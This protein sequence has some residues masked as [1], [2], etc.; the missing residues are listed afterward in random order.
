M[1][2]IRRLNQIAKLEVEL[3]AKRGNPLYGHID[4]MRTAARID[5]LQSR[6]PGAFNP[7]TST[8]GTI[9]T[10]HYGAHLV[11]QKQKPGRMV[12]TTYQTKNGTTMYATY[13]RAGIR[14]NVSRKLLPMDAR[15]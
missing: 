10:Q 2:M 14:P 4:I 12:D 13:V 3:S 6:L 1:S 9:N 7:V 5:T 8:T 15:E 11:L